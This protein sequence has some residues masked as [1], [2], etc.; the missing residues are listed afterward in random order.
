MRAHLSDPA[1][2]HDED[3]TSMSDS[4]QAMG[5][6][7]GRSARG[8]IIQSSLNDSLALRIQSTRCLVQKKQSGLSD[9]CS[10]DSNTLFLTATEL[11]TF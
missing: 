11:S 3:A 2:S 8:C 10:G 7:D 6:C 9:Q 5:H 1:I 4:R